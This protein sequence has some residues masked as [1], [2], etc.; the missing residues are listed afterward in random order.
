L[1]I[2][3]SDVQSFGFIGCCTMETLQ[4]AAFQSFSK[5]QNTR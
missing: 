1:A 5:R 2:A 4:F 3:Q